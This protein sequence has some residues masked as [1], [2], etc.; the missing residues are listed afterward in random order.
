MSQN[1]VPEMQVTDSV[2][3]SLDEWSHCDNTGYYAGRNRRL[4]IMSLSIT[5]IANLENEEYVRHVE[6][7]ISEQSNKSILKSLD[8]VNT[9][10]KNELFLKNESTEDNTITREV[11]IDALCNNSEIQEVKSDLVSSED[12]IMHLPLSISIASKSLDDAKTDVKDQVLPIN[13]LTE[14]NA[15]TEDIHTSA[16]TPNSGSEGAEFNSIKSVDDTA[17]LKLSKQSTQSDSH[18]D[19]CEEDCKNDKLQETDD[20]VESFAKTKLQGNSTYTDQEEYKSQSACR[21]DI[22]SCSTNGSSSDDGC[23]CN[24]DD[25]LQE[26][27]R[28]SLSLLNVPSRLVSSVA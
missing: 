1:P 20:I 8:T 4:S 7:V 26:N 9:D 3:R 19:L 2:G 17:G 12:D 18:T 24:S 15:N 21:I 27:W 22:Y 6:K 13:N 28:K 14:D 25:D 5:N 16:V 11:E 23:S 10:L